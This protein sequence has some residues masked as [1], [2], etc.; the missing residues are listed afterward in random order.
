GESALIVTNTYAPAPCAA[1]PEATKELV[2]REWNDDDEFIFDIAAVTDGAPMP[3]ITFASATKGNLI[4]VFGT[5]EFTEP[6]VYVY[7]ITERDGD[8]PG[9]TYDTEPH[10]VTITVTD[11]GGALEAVID[12][13]GAAMLKIV[14]T[15]DEP[16]PEIVTAVI[17]GLKTIRGIDSTNTV[18]T[19]LLEAL[20]PENEGYSETV[21]TVGAG[22]FMFSPLEFSEE[23]V[24]HFRV[25]ETAGSAS[26]WIYDTTVYNI[27]VTVVRGEDGTLQAE[28]D[29]L[30]NGS[31]FFVNTFI[32]PPPPPP[33]STGD[34]PTGVRL[35]V[36]AVFTAAGACFVTAL[37]RRRKERAEN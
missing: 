4:A 7:T 29:G 24:Y 23:G 25:T 36:A 22:S 33:P 37:R 11:I 28:V 16:G 8:L 35:T 17:P 15:Y 20:D 18:F 6:G 14:N 3:E 10:T 12:Y 31:V 5:I 2:G 21:S 1:N 27:I 19:F 32:T 30:Y 9:V 34:D 26:D 13:D